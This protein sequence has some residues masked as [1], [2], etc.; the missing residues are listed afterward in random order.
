MQ[1]DIQTS[2]IADDWKPNCSMNGTA[3][4]QLEGETIGDQ[5]DMAFLQYRLGISLSSL[6]YWNE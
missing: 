3:A 2:K 1:S 5:L 4:A 6:G